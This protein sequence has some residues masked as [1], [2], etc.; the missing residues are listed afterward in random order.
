VDGSLTPSL[1]LPPGHGG[2][3]RQRRILARFFSPPITLS[4]TSGSNSSTWHCTAM[5]VVVIVIAAA[6]HTGIRVYALDRPSFWWDETFT[7][8]ASESA[9]HVFARTARDVHPP[10][11][12]VLINSWKHAF[13]IHEL[14]LRMPSVLFSTL[15]LLFLFMYVYAAETA[16]GLCAVCVVAALFAFLPYEIHLARFARN[17]TMLMA[18]TTGFAYFYA[19]F[20]VIEDK[21]SFLMALVLAIAVVYTHYLALIFVP[22]FIVSGF[23]AKPT[24]QSLAYGVLALLVVAAAFLPLWKVIQG[25]LVLK[26]YMAHFKSVTHM[27]VYEVLALLNPFPA[28]VL[29]SELKV[30][31][32]FAHA[33][34]VMSLVL[35][36]L[37]ALAAWNARESLRIRMMVIQL[38]LMVTMMSL[39]PTPMFNDRSLCVFLTPLLVCSTHALVTIPDRAGRYIRP[40]IA[41]AFIIISV[42]GFPHQNAFPDWRGALSYVGSKIEPSGRCR[43]I[44]TPPWDFTTVPYYWH[45]GVVDPRLV[46]TRP[47]RTDNARIAIAAEHALQADSELTT[48]FALCSMGSALPCTDLLGKG[49]V[50]VLGRKAFGGIMVYRFGR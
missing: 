49:E 4:P 20:I 27:H 6:I 29:F 35:L 19:N 14:S 16:R 44:T 32:P 42:A 40:T 30:H 50:K 7:W 23:L 37:A 9:A 46:A 39:M 13:G 22:L 24:R 2:L 38:G 48:V 45:R 26:G 34:A 5:L 28:N 47:M 17:Y 18:L 15:T 3:I 31:S 36:G 8:Y 10:A 25:Q 33:G 12:F 43:L 41:A 1:A 11:Y 21:R